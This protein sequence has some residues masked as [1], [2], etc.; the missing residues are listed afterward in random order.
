MHYKRK[1]TIIHKIIS[2]LITSDLRTRCDFDIRFLTAPP[3]HLSLKYGAIIY[4]L[5]TGDSNS[6]MQSHHGKNISLL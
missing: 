2:Q 3:T 1:N 4:H 5:H 6:V